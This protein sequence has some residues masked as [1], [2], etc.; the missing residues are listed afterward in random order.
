M[1]LRKIVALGAAT[2]TLAATSA[3][4]ETW[5]VIEGPTGGIQG[6]WNVTIVGGSVSGDAQMTTADHKP[7]TYAFSGKVDG[8][9]YVIN[10]IKPSDGNECTYTGSSPVTGGLKKATEISGSAMCQTKTGLWKVRI[11]PSK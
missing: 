7:L 6:T 10:R 11:A 1:S 5:K 8:N 4:A 2:L 3:S 9:S